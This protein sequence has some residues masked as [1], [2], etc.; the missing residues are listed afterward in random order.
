MYVK[1]YNHQIKKTDISH[2]ETTNTLVEIPVDK[3]AK[4]EILKLLNYPKPQKPRQCRRQQK[5]HFTNDFTDKTATIFISHRE[6]ADYE[7]ALQLQYKEIITTL[8]DLFVQSDLIEIEFLLANGMLQPVQY[9]S[10]KYAGFSMFKSR[11]IHEIKGKATD[12]PYKKSH[13][14]VQGYNDR[15][16]MALLI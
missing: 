13:L 7:L 11:L 16:K 6:Q 8:G 15:K 4:E 10:N 14:M 5:S 12:K 2:P 9:E 3:L 1:L